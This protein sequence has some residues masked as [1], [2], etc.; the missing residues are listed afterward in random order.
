[1]YGVIPALILQSPLVPFLALIA[2]FAVA[3]WAVMYARNAPRRQ[4]Q[5]T[6]ELMRELAAVTETLSRAEKLGRFGSFTWNFIEKD[7]SYWSDEMYAM[8]GLIKRRTPPDLSIFVA[9]A[10]PESKAAVQQAIAKITTQ[11][12]AFSFT[13]RAIAPD[14]SARYVRVEGTTVLRDSAPWH[15]DGFARDITREME[16]DRAKSEFVSLASHQLKT[17]LASIRWLVEGLM[18]GGAGTFSPAQTKYL[19]GIQ[20]ST[21][22]MIAMVNELLNVSRI[23]LGKIATQ[24][25]ELDAKAL[26]EEVIA[27]QKHAADARSIS[28]ALSCPADLPHVF[29]D[30]SAL[31][32]IFQNLISNAIKYTPQGGS[33]RCELSVSGAK[34][35]AVFLSVSDTGIGIP[36]DEQ[37]RVFEKLHRARNAQALVADGT[38]LGLYVVKTVIEKAG[39]GVTFESKEGKGTT[40]YVTIPLHWRTN[41]TGTLPLA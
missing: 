28:L 27:E 41:G 40:F 1:M 10:A 22:H 33:V 5:R 6:Q 34:N 37:D 38:G 30:R 3:A 16:I 4:D 9:A 25:E 8:F 19:D 36:E 18:S 32:M 17:P 23:E 11:P 2:I 12:G 7:A 13:L 15:I 29:A 21:Q 31:G 24:I 35:E 14:K 20:S 26:A 39:G